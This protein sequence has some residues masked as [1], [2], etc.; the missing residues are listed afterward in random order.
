MVMEVFLLSKHLTRVLILAGS[1][2]V[3]GI[4]MQAFH[5]Q[6]E[7]Q[8]ADNVDTLA[9]VLKIAASIG[10]STLLPCICASIMLSLTQTRAHQR[11]QKLLRELATAHEQLAAYASQVQDLTL[12][13]ERQRL[14]RELHDT[15]AQGLV[16]LKMQ[17]ET[18]D[19]LLEW[20]DVDQAR[21]IVQQAM[22]RVRSALANAR[23][24]ITDLR[25]ELRGELSAA[26]VAEARHFAQMT[27]VP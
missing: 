17:L 3:F 2:L 23:A 4:L 9:L 26:I 25:T 13:T 8:A 20:R 10:G 14:A 24:A 16:G 7:M 27:G 1:S 21:G 12:T 18:I 22:Q 19:A 15:L 5:I 6:A 11:D